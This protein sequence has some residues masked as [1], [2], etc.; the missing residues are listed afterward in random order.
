M[1][2]V[3]LNTVS[4]ASMLKTAVRLAL[5][6]AAGGLLLAQVNPVP[7]SVHYPLLCKVLTFDRNLA[8]RVGDQITVGIIYQSKNRASYR[9]K[10][11]LTTVIS[12]SP[13]NQIKGIPLS[14]LLVDLDGESDWRKEIEINHVDIVY[15][16]PLQGF[17]VGR[18]TDY[19]G[20]HRILTMTGV[21]EYIEM[22]VSLGVGVENNRPKILINRPAS[23][24]EGADFSAQLLA[25][26]RVYQ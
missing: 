17:D 21:P 7:E 25:I 13:Y 6:L 2:R 3:L 15:L 11:N 4:R 5:L 22:G 20:H 8:D 19:T 14:H 24:A 1:I 18:I 12:E 26:A 10:D 23:V 9:V 16:C